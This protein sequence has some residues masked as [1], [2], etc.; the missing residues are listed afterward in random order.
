M[1]TFVEDR[2]RWAT[3][4]VSLKEI[5]QDNRLLVRDLS[6][7][8]RT[9]AIP[10]LA[11]LLTVPELQSH[12]LRLEI[13]V[14]LAVVHCRGRKRANVDDIVRWFSQI[15]KSQCVLGEDAAEDVF[16]ALVQ[17]SDGD[18][19]LLEGVWEAAGFYTQRVLDVIA[20]M[21]DDRQFRR[22]KRSVRAL[23]IISDMV[24]KRSRLHRYQL[25]SEKH[26]S[27]LPRPVLP[28]RSA[29]MSRVTITFAELDKR[30]IT[31]DDLEPFL[32]HPQMQAALYTQRIGLSYLD[33][34]PLIVLSAAGLVVA[35]PSALSVALRDYVIASIA[36]SGMTEAFDRTLAHDYSRLFFDTPLLGGPRRT[37]V[38]WKK[39]GAHQWSTFG[40]S[41]DEGYVISFHLFLPSVQVHSVGGFKDLYHDE[42]D[43]AETLQRSIKETVAHFDQR[44][45]FRKG[46]VVLVGCGWGKGY[47]MTVGPPDDPRWRFENISA[48]DL[49]RLSWHPDMN[50]SYLLRIQDGLETVTKAGVTIVNPNGILNLIG[51]VRRNNGH[52]VPHEQ[53]H[54]V[55]ISHQRPLVIHVPPDLLRQVRADAD[56]GH[57]RHG[58]VDNVGIRHDVARPWPKLYVTSESALRVYASTDDLH[59]GRLTSVYEGALQL[60]L[61]VMTPNLSESDTQYRLWEMASHWL[62]CVGSELD[63]RFGAVLG[64]RNLKVYAEFRDGNPPE[65]G[66]QKP[67]PQDLVRFCTIEPH[68]EPNA[69]KAVFDIGF[70]AG[71]QIAENVAERLFTRTLAWAFLHLLGVDG[72]LRE[73]ET[74]AAL[75]VTNDDARSFH[76]FQAREFMDYVR[77][78]LPKD[79]VAVDIVDGAAVRIGLAQRVRGNAQSNKIEGR[80]ACTSFL[81]KVVDTLLAD[82]SDM[83]KAFDRLSTLERLVANIEKANERTEYWRRTSAAI[84]GLHG[85]VPST[86]EPCVE[87]LS[88]FAGACIAS[89]I[90]TEIALCVCPLEGGKRIS[91][92]ELS[93]LIARAAFVVSLGGLSD[94]IHYN[95]VVPELTISPLGDILLVDEFGCEVVEPMLRRVVGDGF[96]ASASLQRQSYEDP[97]V[98]S[99]VVQNLSDEFLRIWQAEMGFSLHEARS[100]VDALENKGIDAQSAIFTITRSSYLTHVCAAGVSEEAAEQFLDQFSLSPR[101]RWDK[102]PRGF[103]AKDIYP[104]RFGRRLSF[105][106]RP[107]LRIDDDEDPLLLVAPGVLRRSFRYVLDGA[108]RGRFE[109]NFFRTTEMRNNWWGKAR[110]GHTFNAKVAKALA[111]AGWQVRENIRLPELL[112]RKVERD[113]GDVDVLAWRSDREDVL[114]VECKDLASARNYS[115]IAALLSDYQGAEVEGVADKLRRHLNRVTL[116]QDDCAQLQRFLGIP[117]ARIVSCVVFSH[118][119]PMQYAKIDALANTVVGEISDILKL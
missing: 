16:V 38:F 13:L 21:P 94:A 48:A 35:L 107:I 73:A 83:L 15:G 47:S 98:G 102:P 97:E 19:R 71:F 95:A 6:K 93:K 40:L 9:T 78:T 68:D 33:R 62:H 30:G 8:D 91:D 69:C 99:Q 4:S 86:I 72:S 65:G 60:W 109:Q 41:V 101:P 96:V 58:A 80:E 112:Q 5:A 11:G 24:C 85:A 20:T 77:D 28:E 84:V 113:F 81:G 52:L 44:D 88:T 79:V 117:A 50:P 115:E 27:T 3:L 111:D 22:I 7:Y 82:V 90:L 29:L 64:K 70:L 116:L 89:R 66:W 74:V 75:V 55:E 31:P 37:A 76:L 103:H 56:H 118:V 17:D 14:A 10:M 34:C 106:A 46:L 18:Y 2:M 114:V 61:S 59:R 63:R 104:W 45:N 100:T 57:D 36:Q 49:V 43:L 42:G 110:E 53:L 25:G 39:A 54:D 67:T 119:V 51:W 26:H 32:F 23:L 92:I 108:Y 1:K 12:C 87:E 105:A